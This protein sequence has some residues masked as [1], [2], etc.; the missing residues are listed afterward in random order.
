MNPATMNLAIQLKGVSKRFG[1]VVA[2]DDVSIEIPTGVVFALLGENGAGKS[3]AIRIMLGLER[4]DA[5]SSHVLGMDSRRD[6][7]RIR[8]SVGYVPE[9]LSLYQWMTVSEIGWFAAGFH[10]EEYWPRYRRLCEQFELRPKAKI[11]QLSKG[12]KAKVALALAMS[13]DPELLILDEPTSGLDTLVRRQFLES[14]VDLA[15]TGRTVFLSS[16]QIA[17]VERVADRVAFLREGKLILNESLETLLESTQWVSLVAGTGGAQLPALPGTVLQRTTRGK[18]SQLLMRFAAPPE[19][20]ELRRVDGVETVE[21]R[22]AS[23]EDA[24]VAYMQMADPPSP[25]KVEE[26]SLS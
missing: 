1:S 17:E 19:L 21:L 24:F 9:L 12:M 22:P 16:H 10:G 5:G 8:Q 2:L 23:L 15:A 3:T 14:M 13:H 6:S 20:A 18:Q 25:E 7:R 4:P 26:G 11:S